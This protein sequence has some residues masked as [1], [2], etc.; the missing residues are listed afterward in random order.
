MEKKLTLQVELVEL[1]SVEVGRVVRIAF[2]IE[3]GEPGPS[4]FGMSTQHS[5]CTVLGHGQP[6][7]ED[8]NTKLG[9][10]Y[11]VH[12]CTETMC[13]FMLAGMEVFTAASDNLVHVLDN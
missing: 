8:G 11:G 12:Q 9:R 13:P 5:D 6:V 4:N 2:G 3:H 7:C 10:V 1:G